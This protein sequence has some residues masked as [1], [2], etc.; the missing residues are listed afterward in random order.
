LYVTDP[1]T[2]D[3]SDLLCWVDLTHSAYINRYEQ[4]A[5]LRS[6]TDY[7]NTLIDISY[8]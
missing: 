6:D 8:C 2:I 7:I 5:L 4:F 3:V 1:R